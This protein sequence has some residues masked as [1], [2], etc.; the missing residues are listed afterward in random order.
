MRGTRL[1]QSSERLER[2]LKNYFAELVGFQFIFRAVKRPG[3]GPGD[4]GEGAVSVQNRVL[5]S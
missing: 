2:F 5:G 4:L 1:V 3:V